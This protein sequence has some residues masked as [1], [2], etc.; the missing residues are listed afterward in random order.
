M[1]GMFGPFVHRIDPVIGEVAGFYLWWYGLSFTL[2]FLNMHIVVRNYRKRLGLSVASVYELSILLALGVLFGGRAL[3]V[4][5]NEWEF[6]GEHLYLIPAI[7]IDHR[8]AAG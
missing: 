7:W 6:Y 8:L 2:G 3:V 5:N 4:I 1:S